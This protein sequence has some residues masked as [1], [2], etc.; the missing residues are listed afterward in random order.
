MTNPRVHNIGMAL[1]TPNSGLVIPD[2]IIPLS[3]QRMA[4]SGRLIENR[5]L[6]LSFRLNPWPFSTALTH[7]QVW[8]GQHGSEEM[9]SG[10]SASRFLDRTLTSISP[11]SP[12]PSHF[13]I[14]SGSGIL[15]GIQLSLLF[16]Q[17]RLHCSDVIDR[18]LN[19]LT[20]T[21]WSSWFWM[22]LH[23]ASIGVCEEH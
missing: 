22:Q 4:G 10:L 1:L 17:L 15:E 14:L 8:N 2:R 3:S 11:W 16:N 21:F 6:S 13:T 20:L 7:L 23:F 5:P 12:P 18:Q 9:A 19:M